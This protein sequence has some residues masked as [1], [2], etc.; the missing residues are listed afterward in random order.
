MKTKK[1]TRITIR[2][3]PEQYESIAARA[4]TAQMSVGAYVRAAAMAPGYEREQELLKVR[5][6]KLTAEVAQSEK[7]YD[8]IE[9]FLPII[10]KYINIQELDAHILNELIEKIVVHDYALKR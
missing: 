10:W 1:D 9:K 5:R 4:D 2:L 7:V 6:E 3:T 8:N